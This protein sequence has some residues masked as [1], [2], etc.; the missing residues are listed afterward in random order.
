MLFK[1]K[2]FP[3]IIFLTLLFLLSFSYF[4]QENRLSYRAFAQE[5]FD[6][7]KPDD[8]DPF[9]PDSD[10]ELSPFERSR[11]ERFIVELDTQA[12]GLLEE[13]MPDKAF[14]LWYRELRLR[15]ELGV[16]E[17]IEGLSK[18][19][20]IAWDENRTLDARIIGER[21]DEIYL[22]ETDDAEDNDTNI[23]P[24]LLNALGE[25]HRNL[26]NIDNGLKIYEE[27]LSLYRSNNDDEK[28]KPT[29]EIVGELYLAK[30]DYDNAVFVYEELL[31]F[32]Q[33]EGNSF[34]EVE[35][36][37]Q[38]NYIYS[39]TLEPENGIITRKRLVERY[40]DNGNLDKIPILQIA[41]GDDYQLLEKYEEASVV[42]QEAFTLARDLDMLAL[43]G[44]ALKKLGELY[45]ITGNQEFALDIYEELLKVEY[46]TY[47]YY[48]LMN[49]F[50]QIGQ[51]HLE[52]G[53][54][55]QSL[56]AFQKGLDIAHTFGQR[57][58]YFIAQIEVVNEEINSAN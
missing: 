22:D 2:K 3:S 44:D 15:R 47:D 56:D 21:L 11:I 20:K 28:V 49:T 53:N 31:K 40:Q 41:I 23:D 19:G 7:L 29:L 38:L 25:A 10:R 34:E 58:D 12:N 48:N 32:A 54:Y 4:T 51:I 18:V 45:V 24:M 57:V 26:R 16:F 43:A 39:Q 52:L 8:D 9:I 13:G 46:Q 30:F 33:D 42:Y 5:K 50:D 37:N 6:P 36:L 1:L 14:L 17:E 55:S 27:L 35:V